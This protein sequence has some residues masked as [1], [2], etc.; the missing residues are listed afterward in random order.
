[1]LYEHLIKFGYPVEKL[2][3]TRRRKLK[4]IS[5]RLLQENKMTIDNSF[6]PLFLNFHRLSET[7]IRVFETQLF[8]EEPKAEE[9]KKEEPKKQAPERSRE[10]IGRSEF[11]FFDTGERWWTG[12]GESRERGSKRLSSSDLI[13]QTKIST[14]P[15]KIWNELGNPKVEGNT[16]TRK[17]ASII[18]NIGKNSL[19]TTLRE[20]YG[21]IEPIKIKEDGKTREVFLFR[22]LNAL[23]N[24][25]GTFIKLALSC[26]VA[27]GQLNGSSVRITSGDAPKTTDVVVRTIGPLVSPELYERVP[28]MQNYVG[29]FILVSARADVK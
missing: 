16:Q 27:V 6:L 10:R 5:D 26:A 23:G 29:N 24:N 2:P 28:D 25:L 17:M 22:D 11:N 14:E 4:E 7:E 15:E 1:M 18:N 12:W 19:G 13:N 8:E 9:P 21:Q 3:E 20:C